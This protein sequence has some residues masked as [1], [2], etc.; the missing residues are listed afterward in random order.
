MKFEQN[1]LTIDIYGII[2]YNGIG[3]NISRELIQDLHH[4]TTINPE[5]IILNAYIQ[6]KQQIRDTKINQIL[7]ND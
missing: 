1:L 3:L 5:Q 2:Y 7:S 4:Q 6:S